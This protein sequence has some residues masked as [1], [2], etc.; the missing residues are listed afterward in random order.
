MIEEVQITQY[1]VGDRIFDTREEAE[2]YVKEDKVK[3][4]RLKKLSIDANI[5]IPRLL[6]H[7]LTNNILAKADT[8]YRFFVAYNKSDLNFLYRYFMPDPFNTRLVSINTPCIVVIS[9][10]RHLFITTDALIARG[11]ELSD[12]FHQYDTD[13]AEMEKQITDLEIKLGVK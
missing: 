8:R 5:D 2:K 1:K 10:F 4:E 6:Y 11:E 13:L 12:K 9:K 7:N 3:E